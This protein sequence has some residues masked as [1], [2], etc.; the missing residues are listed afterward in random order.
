MSSTNS[1]ADVEITLLEGN[2]KEEEEVVCSK[3]R[4][5]EVK[6][7]EMVGTPTGLDTDT[8]T[9]FPSGYIPCTSPITPVTPSSPR[10]VPILSPL[11]AKKGKKEEDVLLS[12][13]LTDRARLLLNP[14]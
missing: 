13:L 3:K 4:K 7:E 10:M 14:E 12:M 6:K 2:K 9:G 5:V 8:Q 1:N 11:P